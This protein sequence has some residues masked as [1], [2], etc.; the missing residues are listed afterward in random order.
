MLY[1]ANNNST[2]RHISDQDQTIQFVTGNNKNKEKH[3]SI[4]HI[5]LQ[6]FK[7]S[8]EKFSAKSGETIEEYFSND[9][10]ACID[11]GLDET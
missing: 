1:Q 3:S 4:A 7:T 6:C 2:R 9:E 5:M 8:D 10:T 11:Y